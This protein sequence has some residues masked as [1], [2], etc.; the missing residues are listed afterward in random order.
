MVNHIQMVTKDYFKWQTKG[1]KVT[2]QTVLS[3]PKCYNVRLAKQN[4]MQSLKRQKSVN[5]DKLTHGVFSQ[6]EHSA[7]LTLY[8]VE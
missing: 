3:F 6:N 1:K 2:E 4:I 8:T 7:T 5:V